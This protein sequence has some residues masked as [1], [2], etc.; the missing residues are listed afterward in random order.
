MPRHHPP[1]RPPA[2]LAGN[3]SPLMIPHYT[4]RIPKAITF[5]I[6]LLSL[7]TSVLADVKSVDQIVQDANRLLAEGA[8]NEAARAY[9]EA[10][11]ES[12]VRQALM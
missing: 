6:L 7:S 3:L 12:P 4:M 11:G 10:L 9:S 5:P 2:R 1:D 8:Y